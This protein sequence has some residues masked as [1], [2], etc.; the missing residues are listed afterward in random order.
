MT[1]STSKHKK[2]HIRDIVL[3]VSI[4]VGLA[5]LAAAYVYVPRLLASPKHDFVFAKCS[6][7]ICTDSYEVSSGGTIRYVEPVRESLSS[8]NLTKLYYYDVSA[9]STKLISLDQANRYQVNTASRS[10]DGYTLEYQSGS[11][12]GF[13]LFYQEGQSGWYLKN[14]MLQKSATLQNSDSYSSDREIQ[15]LGWIE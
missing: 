14:G 3:L 15:F 6:E 9:D 2:T 4:P 13:L 7:Y 5:L 12:G 10:A 1:A 8:N 11:R